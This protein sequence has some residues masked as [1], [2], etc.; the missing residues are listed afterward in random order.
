M[1]FR[2]NLFKGI[3]ALSFSILA[4]LL[5]KNR[6]KV[7]CHLP[8]VSNVIGDEMSNSR[9]DVND[10]DEREESALAYRRSQGR[11]PVVN[12]KLRGAS[13]TTRTRRLLIQLSRVPCR[14][15][16]ATPLVCVVRTAEPFVL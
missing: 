14:D 13:L 4:M 6:N 12:R 11:R 8:I 7:H 10:N 16:R 1:H 15:Q 9:G 3:S 2:K 5:H